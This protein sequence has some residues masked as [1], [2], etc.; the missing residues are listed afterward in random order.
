MNNLKIHDE[1]KVV[2]FGAYGLLGSYLTPYLRSR[3][4]KVFRQ[5]RKPNSEYLLDPTDFSEVDDFLKKIQPHFIVNLNA[6]TNVD[7]CEEKPEKAYLGNVK[8]IETIEKSIDIT[9]THLIHIST[10]QVYDGIGPHN[11]DNTKP[12]NIYGKSKLQAEQ[13]A[14]K[15]KA[16]IL[17]TNFVGKSFKKKRKSFSDWLVDSFNLNTQINLFKDIKFSA[18]HQEFLSSVIENSFFLRPSE[19]INVGCCD[20]ISKADFALKLANELNFKFTNFKIISSDDFL[21]SARRPKDMSLDTLKFKRIFNKKAPSI[22]DTIKS[23]R[24]DYEKA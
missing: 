21:R 20:S 10:D 13:I 17:R 24:S 15:S 7:L 9:K 22:E 1:T 11:E 2:I 19:T 14:K 12:L 5:G 16:T 6:L 8:T 18:V 4:Y 3:S 23:L